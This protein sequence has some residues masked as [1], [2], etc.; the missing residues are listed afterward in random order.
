MLPRFE[1]NIQRPAK[2]IGSLSLEECRG[3]GHNDQ[4]TKIGPFIVGLVASSLQRKGRAFW[5]VHFIVW[6]AALQSTFGDAYLAL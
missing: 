6:L 2:R 1:K 4:L 3:S 5:V